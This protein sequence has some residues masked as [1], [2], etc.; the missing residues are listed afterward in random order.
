MAAGRLAWRWLKREW[1]GGEL[2]LLFAALALAVTAISAV[3]FFTDRVHRAMTLRASELLAADLTVVS[4]NPIAD[5][6]RR[7]ALAR[8]LATAQTL[9]F[10]SVLSAGERLQLA[11]VKAVGPGYPL[12]G[13]LRVATAPFGVETPVTR[14]PAP[15]AA[16]VD[17][18]LLAALDLRLGGPVRVGSAELRLE[19]VIVFEPDR[20]GDLFSLGPRVMVH[21]ADVAATSLVQPGSRVTHRLLVAGPAAALAGYRG[22]L[23]GRLGPGETLQDVREARPELRVALERAERFL[24]LAALVSVLLAGV[25]G[26]MV[27]RRYAARHLDTVAVLRCLGADQSTVNRLFVGQV[28]M[29]GLS[30]GLVGVVAGYGAQS[31][32]A[33]LL[34][35]LFP[36]SLP[37]PSLRPALAGLAT[38]LLTLIGFALPALVRLRDV[39]PARVLRRDLAPLPPRGWLVF[40]SAL[41]TL[42]LLVL[43]QAGDAV[44]AAYAL[45]G[46]AATV[47][48]LAGGAAALVAALRPLRR[49]VGV[50]WR[51]GM[52]SIARRARASTLQ[53]VA[54][55]LGIMVL[56]LLTVVRGE[57]LQGWRERLPPDAPN[58]FLINVQPEEAASVRRFLADRGVEQP[59]LYPMVRGRLVARNEAPV[60]PEDYAEGRARRLVER[61]FNLSWAASPQV[62]NRIVAGAWWTPAEHGQAVISVEE[63][64]ADTLGLRLGDRLTFRVAGEEVTARITSLRS[65]QWDS[66]RVNFFV[67]APPGL[68]EGFPTTYVTSFH[69]PRERDDVLSELVR[70]YPSVTVLDVEALLERVRSILDQTAAAVQY[71]F[72]FTLL[73]G[74]TVLVSA[75]QST[76]D[77]RRFEGA[78]VRALGGSR[79]QLLGSLVAEFATLGA[80]AGLLAASAAAATGVALGRQVFGLGYWP[81]PELWIYGLCAGVLGVGLTGVLGTRRVLDHPP[82]ESLRRV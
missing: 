79:R 46:T 71:V 65:V 74:I 75:V 18:R 58:H 1:R 80:L 62:D 47:A 13:A 3:G 48:L 11:E 72:L 68:L 36:G 2:L 77:E 60:V 81:G 67:V 76:L 38:G 39:P 7:E 27:A 45:G 34:G 40:G 12:R 55:G 43:W 51:Y 52:A 21:M 41:A 31:V 49:R 82:V 9:T 42:M 59:T 35:G 5:S 63:G 37:A 10:P 30:A 78:V 54:F 61:E 28:L 6:L 33:A 69:L 23:A 22:W 15:G 24:G 32:L 73:A 25:T 14:G 26:A 20:P 53:L 70:G 57:L 8:G 66:F 4:S 19:A 64:I 16:W 44:L 17:A 29:V 50:A 56:L